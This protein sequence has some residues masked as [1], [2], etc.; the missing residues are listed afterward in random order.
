MRYDT[1][2]KRGKHWQYLG[3]RDAETM[4]GAALQTGYVHNCKVVAVRPAGSRDKLY[5]YRFLYVP[6]LTSGK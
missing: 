2:R 4:R 3:E 1:Y 5:V 6:L